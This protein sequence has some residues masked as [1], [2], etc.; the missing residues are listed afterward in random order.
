MKSGPRHTALRRP[1][2][3]LNVTPRRKLTTLF[4]AVKELP[5]GSN[6][7]L[8]LRPPMVSRISRRSAAR[9][10]SH[11]LTPHPSFPH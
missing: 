4:G 11:I 2:F 3:Y 10:I 8:M 1:R 9:F 5:E 6:S 7:V